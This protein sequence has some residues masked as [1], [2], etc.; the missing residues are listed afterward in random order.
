MPGGSMITKRVRKR[1]PKTATSNT[2]NGLAGTGS[3]APLMRYGKRR[4][5]G[6]REAGSREGQREGRAQP[7]APGTG[8]APVARR[9][10]S[11]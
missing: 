5:G 11:P 2:V 4:E 7:P 9:T 6:R 1:E 3:G 10:I 8:K